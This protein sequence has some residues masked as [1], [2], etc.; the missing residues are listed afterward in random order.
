MPDRVVVVGGGLAGLAATVA[1]ASRGV[2]V[3]LLESRS[4]LG[5]R[6]SSF[7]D[8]TT[9]S[10]IDNCQHVTM[11]CCTNF[12][13]FCQTTGIDRYLQRQPTLY[14]V[15]P[16]GTINP[17]SA[18]WLPAPFHLLPS[19]LRLSYFNMRDLRT[20]ARGL[21][22]L[23]KVVP[24]DFRNMSFAD[25]MT[26]HDQPQHVIEN[27]WQVVL[28]SAL[29]EDLDR[30]DVSY[31]R[32][33][34]A[35]GFVFNRSG[36]EVTIP[37]VPL[38]EL[39]GS[40]LTEWLEKHDVDVQLNQGVQKFNMADRAIHSAQ[41]RDGSEIAANDWIVAV[42]QHRVSSLFPDAVQ[43]VDTLNNARQLTTAPI[44]SVH[45]WFDHPITD[46][47]HAA[48]VGKLSQW[49]FNRTKIQHET[50][51]PS[52]SDT[53]HENW[54]Y[55]Q[56]VI[57]ASH[58][59]KQLSKNE[60]IAKVVAELAEIWP[61]N[62]SAKL[63]HSRLVIEQNAVFSA[64][65]SVDSLRPKQQSTFANLQWAGDWTNTGWPATM[66]GAIRSGYLAAENILSR[67]NR[68]ETI[69]QPDQTASRLAA[70]V[71]GY[72]VKCEI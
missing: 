59:L 14:F 27:F 25:W 28:V 18:S 32:K 64:V 43:N 15:A 53:K 71:F 7:F 2:G 4:R 1:L 9:E 37:Q 65:P 47:P 57:S 63:M 10:W 56:V 35:D 68:P 69:R 50:T 58:G 30:I 42:P 51:P 72:Q 54:H 60:T 34:F 19:F 38:E 52:P 70:W 48:I 67:Q 11:G 17:F 46:L 5:G 20:I 16:D 3:T 31:A 22:L 45:L 61:V 23:M 40:V 29:S 13:H 55:Y 12:Q 21:R 24:S 41:L 8:S 49:M 36:W 62:P 39:Y 33:V 6:A 44:A 66:E 26:K